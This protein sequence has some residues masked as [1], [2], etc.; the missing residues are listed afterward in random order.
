MDYLTFTKWQTQFLRY[1]YSEAAKPFLETRRKIEAEEPP[2]EPSYSE[3]A[4]PAFL[5]EWQD[6]EDALALLGQCVASL[7][8]DRLKLYL[9]HWV[10]ELRDSAGDAQ[11]KWEI[12]DRYGPGA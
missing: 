12:L 3:D 5:G 11:L 10:R 7:L 4:E 6:A 1:F 9:E 2:F 8:S